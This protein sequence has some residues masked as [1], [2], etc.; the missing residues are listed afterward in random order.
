MKRI[1]ILLLTLLLISSLQIFPQVERKEIGNLVLE[2]VPEIPQKI[3]DRVFQY[4]STRAA[5]FGGWLPDDTGILI[6]TRF[7]ETAQIHL[8]E[9][10][11][12]ARKQLTFFPEPVSGTSICPDNKKGVFLF[13]KDVGG[14]EFY[15]IF[16]F[17]LKTGEYKML[18]DGKS[19]NAGGLWS[20]EG[21]KFAYTS[22]K[23]N[24]T[25][26]DIYMMDFN[27]GIEKLLL[28]EGGYWY[29]TDW[30]PDDSK[31]I[32]G[33]YVSANESHI[34]VFDLAS[35]KLEEINPS[36][37]KIAYSRTLWSK[38]GKG[39][40][41][42]SDE[43]SE[44]QQL[45]YYELA[46]KKF[47]VV[48]K[49]IN[50]DVE[51][52]AITDKGDKLAFTVNEDGSSKLYLTDTKTN[53]Y[54]PVKNLPVGSAYSL[55]FNNKGNKLAF[56]INSSKTPGDVYSLNLN[57]NSI[58]RWTYS[59]V[60]G[61]NTD[62]F[63]EPELIHY[64]TFDKVDGKQ[65]VI[66]AFLY[67]PKNPK[68]PAPVLINI[69]GGPEGQFQPGF[70]SFTQYL[71]NE[72]G[73]AVIGPNVR[74]STGY[75]K[76]YVALD[77]WYK[78]EESVQDIGE[79]LNW[80]KTQ[81]DLDANKVCVFGGSYGGYMVLASMFHY[82]NK[83]K[84][85]IDIVGISNF[86]TFLNNTQSYRRDLRRVEYG[87]ERIPEVKEFLEKTAP[88]NN[89]DKISKPM[90]V[91]QGLNDPRVPVTEAEQMV[92]KMRENK[93]SVWYM[94]A[95]DEGHGFQKKSNRDYMTY[96]VYLFLEENLL[97]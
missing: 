29:P 83:L 4:Q 45:K 81:P 47:T 52:I 3:I 39:I 57:D 43:G 85:G 12:G 56:T 34:Y 91:I 28:A 51:E 35:K 10:P 88:L 84:C 90:F 19:R 61:L 11:G 5:S 1:S 32:V 22:T 53:K 55:E 92:A 54:T 64:P 78:R 97:K 63:V 77:N 82:N 2:N 23:R 94:L 38:D 26:T 50:W 66:P 68:E 33:K 30:S 42:V 73:I 96:A 49:D 74:G 71:V 86:N 46:A 89:A 40:Y 93:S 9:K 67:K 72:M 60:G 95:K 14:G 80:I 31:I 62:N 20:N 36:G 79:L 59:E 15:Q 37:D 17:N 13:L 41:F 27:S 65:R 48:S 69:H 76:T 25:D 58:E 6:S 8:V 16:S 70:S 87:D 18:T 44:F 24:G 75:G 21:N 7:G